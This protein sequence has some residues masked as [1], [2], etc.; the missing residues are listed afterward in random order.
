MTRFTGVL[1][2][3]A[4]DGERLRVLFRLTK[5]QRAVKQGYLREFCRPGRLSHLFHRF[6]IEILAHYALGDVRV[7]GR[8]LDH[9]PTPELREPPDAEYRLGVVALPFRENH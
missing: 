8:P 2:R 1:L 3:E 4:V 6:E 9:S 7:V 5:I